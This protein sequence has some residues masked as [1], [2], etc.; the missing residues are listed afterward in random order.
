MAIQYK[1]EEKLIDNTN[2]YLF[3]TIIAARSFFDRRKFLRVC[4][5]MPDAAEYEDTFTQTVLSNEAEFNTF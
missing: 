3:L 2:V 5:I 1:V 4:A